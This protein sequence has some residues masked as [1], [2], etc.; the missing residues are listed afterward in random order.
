MQTSFKEGIGGEKRPKDKVKTNDFNENY[1]IKG[2]FFKFCDVTE[3]SIV[4]R[5]FSQLWIQEN[6]RVKYI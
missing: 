4:H 1:N 2:V 5:Q 6:M 3:V